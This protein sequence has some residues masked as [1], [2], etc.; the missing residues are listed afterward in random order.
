MRGGDELKREKY[1]KEAEMYIKFELLYYIVHHVITIIIMIIVIIIILFIFT[2]LVKE[3][4]QR[5]MM[6]MKKGKF[7]TGSGLLGRSSWVFD[8]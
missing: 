1:E 3:D 7:T 5:K 2:N 6:I 8:K 4:D